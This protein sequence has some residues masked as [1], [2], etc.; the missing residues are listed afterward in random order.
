MQTQVNNMEIDLSRTY[1][2]FMG[3]VFQKNNTKCW[4]SV[5]KEE[6]SQENLLEEHLGDID[7]IPN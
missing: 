7:V 2:L 1:I 6:H 3:N 4:G 5:K